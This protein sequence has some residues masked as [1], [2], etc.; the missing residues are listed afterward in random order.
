MGLQGIHITQCSATSCCEALLHKTQHRVG[1]EDN[2]L[3]NQCASS[4]C[5]TTDAHGTSALLAKHAGHSSASAL[6]QQDRPFREV[7]A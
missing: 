7:R 4:V 2:Q 1:C 5:R 6:L 3:E